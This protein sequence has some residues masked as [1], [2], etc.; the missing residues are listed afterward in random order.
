M[1]INLVLDMWFLSFYCVFGQQRL[2][3]SKHRA[4]S[5]TIQLHL[6]VCICPISFCLLHS[7]TWIELFTLHLF[8]FR[9]GLLLLN[10][11]R[12]TCNSIKVL[13]RI[14]NKQGCESLYFHSCKGFACSFF[15]QPKSFHMAQTLP[16]LQPTEIEKSTYLYTQ[17]S[18]SRHFFMYCCM[19]RIWVNLELQY[20]ETHHVM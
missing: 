19:R 1:A 6:V 4:I 20:A 16:P 5:Y 14:S 8:V 13:I 10:V 2:K 7:M 15:V 18:F 12:Y 11:L 17:V 3:D 9:W